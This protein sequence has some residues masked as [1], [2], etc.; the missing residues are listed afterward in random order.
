MLKSSICASPAQCELGEDT[1]RGSER[2]AR[3]GQTV[4]AA[5]RTKWTRALLSWWNFGFNSAV[6]EVRSNSGSGSRNLPERCGHRVSP[7]W[8]GKN[9]TRGRALKE[10]N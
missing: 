5:E 8:P 4:W 6:A 3:S 1:P 9:M 10:G 7:P 2:K